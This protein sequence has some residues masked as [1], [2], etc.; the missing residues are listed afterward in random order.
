MRVLQVHNRYSLGGG[1]DTISDAE[2][3]LLQDAGHEVLR[4]RVDN[5][6][7]GAKAA[8]AF[9]G[10]VFNP[11]AAARLRAEIRAFRPDVAH[12]HNTWFSLSPQAFHV[13]ADERVPIVMTLQNYRL[14]CINGLLF[15]D[16]RPCTDC[17]GSSPWSGVQ[18]R[19]YRGSAAQ[20]TVA[21]TTLRVAQARGTWDLVDRFLAPSTFVRDMFVGAGYDPDRFQVRPN[22]VP[23][24]GP[25][26]APPSASRTVLYVGRL[27]PEK[28]L[29]ELV[30]GWRQAGD[31]V[32]DLELVIVGEGPLLDDLKGAAPDNVRF[33]GWMDSAEV[34][35]QMLSA[36]ALAFPSQWYE[37]FGRVSIEA[38]AAGMPVLASDIATPG[39]V[40]APLGPRW[41]V[42]P[43]SSAAWAE[44]LTRLGDDAEVDRAGVRARELFEERYTIAE[45]LRSLLA[46]YHAVQA[47]PGRPKP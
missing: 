34:T 27:S 8:V 33:T 37:N 42:P 16:G 32:A 41:L 15:R 17:V 14:M 44:A 23:D 13:L 40:V 28:G 39:E 21:A 38:M 29:T 43:G 5:P 45:G 25:R 46:A 9:S 30:A 19:C 20:S 11:R 6:G 2:A 24:P 22:V 31:A 7:S 3:A 36:R 18:H 1:E 12:V 26:E 35:Q 10:A 4:Y 47:Q